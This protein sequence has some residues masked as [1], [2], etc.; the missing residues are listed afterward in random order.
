MQIPD[1][2]EQTSAKVVSS[3]VG[4]DWLELNDSNPIWLAGERVD[5]RTRLA[6]RYRFLCRAYL[7]DLGGDATTAQTGLFMSA[8][9]LQSLVES[10]TADL[11]EAAR[12]TRR[13]CAG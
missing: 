13:S 1:R 4:F 7:S 9:T 12:W 6:Q 5:G 11:L 3:R 2:H 8:A 10:R